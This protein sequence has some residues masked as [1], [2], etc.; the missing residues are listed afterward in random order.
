[1]AIGERIKQVRKDAELTLEKFAERIGIKGPS[2]SM[3]ERGIS[4]PSQQTIS[5]ICREFGVNEDWLRTGA[6]EMFAKTYESELEKMCME[7]GL[8]HADYVAVRN[9][10][11][12]PPKAR[13]IVTKFMRDFARDV[14]ANAQ[15]E[16]KNVHDWTDAEMHAELQRQL[17]AEKRETDGP[18]TSCSGS[19]GAATA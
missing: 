15:P 3:I 13:D 12:L 11:N 6:G 9:F 1:M 14:L 8:S 4:N 2:V 18:S 7:R 17:D 5:L 10:M 19:S 16:P